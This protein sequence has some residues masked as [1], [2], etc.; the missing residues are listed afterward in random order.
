MSDVEERIDELYNRALE[1]MEKIASKPDNEDLGPVLSY[2]DD[3]EDIADEA[4]D[5]LSRVD[6]TD[7]ADSV[8]WDEV[9][10]AFETEDLY[11]MFDEDEDTMTI[12]KLLQIVDMSQLWSSVNAREMWREKREFED[13]LDDVTDDE[14]EEEVDGS[15]DVSMP[16][17][18]I[19]DFDPETVENAIQSQ[20]SDSIDEFREALIDAH[21]R[22]KEF[23]ENN[24]DRFPDRRRSS[25]RNPTAAST[26]PRQREA[27][28]RGTRYS[29]VPSETKYSS[30]PNRERI[31]G[32]RFEKAAEERED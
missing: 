1:T 23:R 26:L 5:I 13:E 22:L 19:E 8:E 10:D 32:N 7:L 15:M 2:L 28:G 25:S 29:T 31:Y 11:A 24:K 16:N 21:V 14:A 27:L 9:S 17:A 30:A 18:G 4:E 20:M 3:L 12:G 6:L